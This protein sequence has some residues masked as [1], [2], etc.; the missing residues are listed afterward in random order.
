MV[1]A[2]EAEATARCAWGASEWSL[3]EMACVRGLM[4]VHARD[5]HEQLGRLRMLRTVDVAAIRGRAG[6][7]EEQVRAR[8]VAAVGWM[9]A[10][11]AATLASA[12]EELDRFIGASGAPLGGA[13][14]QRA[15]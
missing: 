13:R 7:K 2:E 6:Y 11:S 9:A 3:G 15:R 4:E 14:R 12:T 1:E 10:A 8:V 5:V